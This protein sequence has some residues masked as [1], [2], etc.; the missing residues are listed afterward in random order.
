MEEKIFF[1]ANVKHITLFLIMMLI[2]PANFAL[3]ANIT[4]EFYPLHQGN[5]WTY[6][7][8]EGGGSE[9]TLRINGEEIISGTN[10]VKLYSG[11]NSIDY[12]YE[13]FAFDSEG[14]KKYK[15]VDMEDENY[16]IFDPPNIE[17][18]GNIEIGG[19]V[20]YSTNLVISAFDNKKIGDFR[21]NVQ[22]KLV[23]AEDVA[24]PAGKFSDCLKFSLDVDWANTES[25]GKENRIFWLARGVG[26]VKEVRIT[27]ESAKDKEME[28]SAETRVLA[29]AIIDGKKIGGL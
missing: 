9:E 23:S 14:V 7:T 20:N 25:H 4:E 18:P 12:E 24:V 17:V 10:T 1:Q 21:V 27:T 8:K 15:T 28:I 5:T 22:I 3:A 19:S 13:C 26:K 11:L 6:A 29:S 16:R 2:M